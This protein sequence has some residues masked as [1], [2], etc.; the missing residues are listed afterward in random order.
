[1]AN[2]VDYGYW[3]QGYGDVSVTGQ[4]TGTTTIAINTW[5]YVAL[6]RSGGTTTL[7]LNGSV[8][9]TPTS[10]AAKSFT[11]TAYRIG[12][13]L[14]SRNEYFYGYMEEVRFTKYARTITTPTE[15]FPVQ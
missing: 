3:V 14:D 13:S 4:I 8:E 2:Y 12:N 9:G 10:W 5:Y 1:M 7:Y 6:V 15:A 11:S